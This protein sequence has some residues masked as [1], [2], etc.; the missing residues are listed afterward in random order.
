MV[1]ILG[2]D[3][4]QTGLRFGRNIITEVNVMCKCRGSVAWRRVEFKGIAVDDLRLVT[5]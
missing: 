1:V 3:W 4:V 5:R 2:A